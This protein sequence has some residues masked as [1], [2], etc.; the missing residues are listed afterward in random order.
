MVTTFE[1][2][3]IAILAVGF[4]IPAWVMALSF[5]ERAKAMRVE[6]PNK[7]YFAYAALLQSLHAQLDPQSKTVRNGP[8]FAA[9]VRELANYPEYRS[10]SVLF[11]EEITITGTRKFDQVVRA[12]LKAVEAQLLDIK[13]PA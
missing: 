12:E 11:L 9:T 7:R 6:E 13:E 3:I 4:V 5:R 10:F 1:A 8:L 2:A